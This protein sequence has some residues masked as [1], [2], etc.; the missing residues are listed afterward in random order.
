MPR[1]SPSAVTTR[2]LSRSLALMVPAPRDRLDHVFSHPVLER[3]DP[4]FVAR[5]VDHDRAADL[6]DPFERDPP[7]LGVTAHREAPPHCHHPGA[8]PPGQPRA[9]RLRAHQESGD[10]PRAAAALGELDVVDVA[11]QPAVLVDHL[12]V[13]QPEVQVEGFG[14]HHC[15]AAVISMSGIAATD[16]TTTTIRKIVPRTLATGPLTRR[17]M[18]TG[19]LATTRIGK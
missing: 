19:S 15:P 10:V 2:A 11:D 5:A 18:Y 17:P 8:E 1:S 13:E 4:E 6:G 7:R 16:A 9:Q 3:G 12:V 14:C